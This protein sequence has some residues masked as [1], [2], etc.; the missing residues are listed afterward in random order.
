M[1]RTIYYVTNIIM[2]KRFDKDYDGSPIFWLSKRINE[3]KSMCYYFN[4][5]GGHIE[6]GAS[7]RQTLIQ[8]TREEASILQHKDDYTFEFIQR[9]TEQKETRDKG[10]RVVFV[11]SSYTDQEPITP[12]E[13]QE[14]LSQW[15]LF[16][17]Q[18]ILKYKTVDSFKE[19][20]IRKLQEIPVCINHIS[21][22]GEGRILHPS[23]GQVN[24]QYLKELCKKYKKEPSILEKIILYYETKIH[25]FSTRQL[26]NIKRKNDNN[27]REN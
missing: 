20:I 23:I 22:R 11:Y 1:T 25:R 15:E 3:N 9:F 27:R 18:E 17:L 21:A 8:E 26:P 6:P 13:E 7:R 24:H 19:Y 14:N 4:P 16:T 2:K 10:M 5:P 12:I